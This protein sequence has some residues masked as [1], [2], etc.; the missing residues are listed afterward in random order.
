MRHPHIEVAGKSG[1]ECPRLRD[2]QRRA[3]V[4][5]GPRLRDGAAQG[6]R[7][8]LEPVAN[9]EDRYTGIEEGRVE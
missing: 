1:E 2:R 7:H 8:R 3:A 5:A 4:L 6:L 9:A